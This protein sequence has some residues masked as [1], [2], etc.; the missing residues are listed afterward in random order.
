MIRHSKI[1]FFKFREAI[2]VQEH[3]HY[4]SC[5]AAQEI[6]LPKGCFLWRLVILGLCW[7]CGVMEAHIMYLPRSRFCADVAS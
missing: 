7:C 5:L 1:G 4:T 3:P 2:H 6:S